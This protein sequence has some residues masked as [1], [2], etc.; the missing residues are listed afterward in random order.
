MNN[1][2][3]NG[4]RRGLAPR[5][6]QAL[7][8]RSK[9]VAV[10]WKTIMEDEPRVF[11]PALM[12]WREAHD[13]W[14]QQDGNAQIFAQLQAEITQNGN[15]NNP[16]NMTADGNAAKY[17]RG[18]RAYFSE[19][20]AAAADDGRPTELK[21]NEGNVRDEIRLDGRA[22]VIWG[23][24]ADDLKRARA[25]ANP[26]GTN[27]AVFGAQA[28]GWF[29]TYATTGVW[30]G[31]PLPAN[32]ETALNGTRA[33]ISSARPA[34]YITIPG[35]ADDIM[36]DWF[37][38]VRNG[39]AV[40]DPATFAIVTGLLLQAVNI[41]APA[42]GGQ[43][44]G[45]V[46]NLWSCDYLAACFLMLNRAHLS[47]DDFVAAIEPLSACFKE[48]TGKVNS[49]ARMATGSQMTQAILQVLSQNTHENQHPLCVTNHRLR[50]ILCQ[51]ASLTDAVENVSLGDTTDIANAWMDVQVLLEEAEAAGLAD[52]EINSVSNIAHRYI[53]GFNEI[54]YSRN[55]LRGS[56]LSVRIIGNAMGNDFDGVKQER[57]NG[58]P[59]F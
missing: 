46:S 7:F 57:R 12:W 32:H 59:Q 33:M 40:V 35:R 10:R 47:V 53:Q 19:E 51:S 5:A 56:A 8:G 22:F 3:N 50:T 30:T 52:T 27:P 2:R 25:G 55:F 36:F 49:N 15:T 23:A 6:N 58:M 45:G 17:I 13:A 20:A 31:P 16:F 41:A 21:V 28:A 39:G 29:D 54:I 9:A 44:G 14:M 43:Q 38:F 26:D 34:W 24:I 42:R 11:V 37:N 1:R 18:V 48:A 4:R